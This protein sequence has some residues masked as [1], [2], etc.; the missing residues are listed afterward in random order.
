MS[1]QSR[2][3]ERTQPG[4]L[5]PGN[6][7]KIVRPHQEH[8]GGRVGFVRGKALVSCGNGGQLVPHVVSRG[9]EAL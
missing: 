1:D 9:F 3:D 4:V 8:G 7:K 2:R 6:S 5:T